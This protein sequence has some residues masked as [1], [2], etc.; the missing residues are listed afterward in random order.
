M[1]NYSVAELRDK[2]KKKQ[3]KKLA[4]NRVFPIFVPKETHK[5]VL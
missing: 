4:H 2:L 5:N 3:A 1:L